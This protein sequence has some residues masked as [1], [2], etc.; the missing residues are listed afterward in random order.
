MVG[1]RKAES[2]T[3]SLFLR[4]TVELCFFLFI[5]DLI[6]SPN[7]LNWASYME[8]YKTSTRKSKLVFRV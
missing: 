3:G 1:R 5:V 6:F 8:V 4:L 2:C 7:D